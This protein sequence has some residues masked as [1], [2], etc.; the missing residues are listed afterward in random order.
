MKK[1]IVQFVATYLTCQLVKAE[2]K[3]P[4][5][6]L[7]SLDIQKCK[8]EHIIMNFVTLLPRMQRY[9]FGSSFI[10]L[11]SLLASCQYM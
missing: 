9:Q 7:Q 2:H 11:L 10:G 8:W 4:S 3:K 5:C 6:F 1:D